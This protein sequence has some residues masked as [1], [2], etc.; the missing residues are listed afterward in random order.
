VRIDSDVTHIQQAW[1]ADRVG[2][3]DPHLDPPADPRG[4]PERRAARL[5]DSDQRAAGARQTDAV[6]LSNAGRRLHALML[7]SSIPRLSSSTGAVVDA[8]FVQR[9]LDGKSVHETYRPLYDPRLPF[10]ASRTF[11]A[12]STLVSNI[13]TPPVQATA[14]SAASDI[15][16]AGEV[17]VVADPDGGESSPPPPME[18]T[19]PEQ[20]PAEAPPPMSPP[21]RA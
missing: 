18:P 15:A 12:N 17:P 5:R 19:V 1:R 6:Y 14:E 10:G 9:R 11:Y 4:E 7:S 13:E 20:P 16:T 3:I 21:A 8:P 2:A